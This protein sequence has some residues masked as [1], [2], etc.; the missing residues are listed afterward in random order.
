MIKFLDEVGPFRRG[1]NLSEIYLCEFLVLLF[2]VQML[3]ATLLSEGSASIL[4][5]DLGLSSSSSKAWREPWLFLL[6]IKIEEKKLG[7][8]L[9]KLEVDII[10]LQ[11]NND[12]HTIYSSL[13][14][15]FLYPIVGF[16]VVLLQLIA[17]GC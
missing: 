17:D 7:I 14:F 3:K 5:F 10:G 1:K 4:Q 12:I 2:S 15:G 16:L 6:R 13:I 8:K 11:N 9:N